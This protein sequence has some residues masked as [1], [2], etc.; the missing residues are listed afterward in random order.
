[1]CKKSKSKYTN[2][3]T[4]IYTCIIEFFLFY[5]ANNNYKN[6]IEIHC[7]TKDKIFVNVSLI[8]ILYYN[9]I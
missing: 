6:R 9:L 4:K 2:C 7:N 1:M 5:K 3:L 8:K